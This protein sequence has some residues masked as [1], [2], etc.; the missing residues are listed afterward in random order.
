MASA[1]AAAVSA[2]VE[3]APPGEVF[4]ATIK[5]SP[6]ISDDLAAC[7]RDSRYAILPTSFHHV[8]ARSQ[9]L[10]VHRHQSPYPRRPC[11]SSVGE[12]SFREV[13][14]GAIDHSQA[15]WQRKNRQSI[16]FNLRLSCLV[17]VLTEEGSRFL[18]AHT[19]RL[20]GGDIMMLRPRAPS[21]LITPPK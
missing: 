13:Q 17:D 16:H 11:T 21:H 14:R 19:I 9:A 20:A 6:D 2:F 7:R 18:S 4:P 15:A 12:A 8:R 10:I 1:N 5:Y 3:G